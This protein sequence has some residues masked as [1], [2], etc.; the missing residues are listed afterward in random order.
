MPDIAICFA[1]LWLL[2]NQ[3]VTLRCSRSQQL[4]VHWANGAE[5][6]ASLSLGPLII[7]TYSSLKR[8]CGRAA[9]TA[10]VHISRNDAFGLS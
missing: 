8:E 1:D 9:S 7:G 3:L 4:V 2:G 5:L 10:W 6:A